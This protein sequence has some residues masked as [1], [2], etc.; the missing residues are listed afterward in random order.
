MTFE[1][2]D[3]PGRSV[4]DAVRRG[5]ALRCPACGRGAMFR[6]FLKVSE[7]CPRCGEALHHQRADDAPPYFTILIVGHV[8]VPAA[9][10]AEQLAAP[11][12]WLHYAVWLPLTVL[13]SLWSLSRV[14][15]ALVGFQWARRMH[16]FGDH[17]E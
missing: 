5:F 17:G 11:P 9:L 10:I 12:V 1:I 8:V 7:N 14:K 2:S 16:G 6:R 4:W 3:L 15:G 13:L